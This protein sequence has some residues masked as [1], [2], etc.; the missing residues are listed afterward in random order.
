MR[1][2]ILFGE[3]IV[4]SPHRGDAYD[5]NREPNA[6]APN[7]PNLVQPLAGAD[8]LRQPPEPPEIRDYGSRRQRQA[9]T[10]GVVDNEIDRD[11]ELGVLPENYGGRVL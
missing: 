10:L 6:F 9:Y 3:V 5:A 4:F 2:R 8:E 11:V 7:D 1:C